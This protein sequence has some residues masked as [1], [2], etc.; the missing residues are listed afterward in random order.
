MDVLDR[1][2]R[3]ARAVL[4]ASP[5]RLADPDPVARAIDGAADL[6]AVGE[7]LDQPRGEAIALP[8][9]RGHPPEAQAHDTRREIVTGHGRT[10]QQAAQP[11][12]AVEVGASLGHR[13]PDP[14]IARGQL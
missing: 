3:A 6:G 4:A 1:L 10:N 14:R 2:G 5:A 11:D 8:E 13:P 12:H 7:T 9:V